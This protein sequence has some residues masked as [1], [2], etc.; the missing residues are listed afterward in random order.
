MRP[1]QNA[2]TKRFN[3]GTTFD[4]ILTI[5]NLDRELRLLCLDAIERIEIA[6]R[7]AI[8][9]VLAV[10]YGAHFYLRSRH[11]ETYTTFNGFMQKV[12]AAKYLAITHYTKSYNDP[13]LPPSWVVLQAI[14]FG[15]LSILYSGLHLSNRK[16]IAQS[17]NYDET[18]LVFWFRSLNMVRNMCAHHNRMWNF[19]WQVDQP[20]AANRLAAV[21][22]PS[23]NKFYA[24]AVVLVA[25][26]NQIEPKSTW[27]NRLLSLLSA[28]PTINPAQMG[29]PAGWQAFP[30]WA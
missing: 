16:L 4:D 10:K 9:N 29:F 14:T 11:F 25:L 6:L 22:S 30:F 20:M 26:L 8:I 24:R 21:W 2:G 5:Y 7:S 17:F 27:K 1:L 15:P 18:I 12:L 28:H 19:V 3:P 23:Q 13:P